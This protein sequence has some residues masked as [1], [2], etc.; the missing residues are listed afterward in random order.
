LWQK[1]RGEREEK[2]EEREYR[3]E[4]RRA[5]S[6]EKREERGTNMLAGWS[7]RNTDIQQLCNATGDAVELLLP[8]APVD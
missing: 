7:E 2:R 3:R 8:P 4:G 6:E 5:K 1:V